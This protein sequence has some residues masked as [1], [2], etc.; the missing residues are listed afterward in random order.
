MGSS[1]DFY[2]SN[3]DLA[4]QKSQS[5]I[6]SMGGPANAMLSGTC[7]RMAFNTSMIPNLNANG[8]MITDTGEFLITLPIYKPSM[9]VPYPTCQFSQDP[10][11]GK[12]W[13]I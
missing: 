7:G 12:M 10:L 8:I 1:Y 4:C 13:I 6:V 11:F 9:M 3:N 2:G 5:I